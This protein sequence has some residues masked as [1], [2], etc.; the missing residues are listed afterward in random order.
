MTETERKEDRDFKEWVARKK[1]EEEKITHGAEAIPWEEPLYDAYF[2]IGRHCIK[3]GIPRI[4][5][6]FFIPEDLKEK[7]P[8]SVGLYGYGFIML[9]K[10]FYQE[11]GTDEAVINTL[12]HEMIHCYCGWKIPEKRIKDTEGEYHLPAFKEACEANGG[13]CSF[14]DAITGYSDARLTPENMEKVR[15]T[16]EAKRR[17]GA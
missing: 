11:H 9:Q 1:E 3:T 8:D 7:H 5:K 10:E 13:I 16:I 15:R 6:L 14:S 2:S 17:K 12:F 4:M